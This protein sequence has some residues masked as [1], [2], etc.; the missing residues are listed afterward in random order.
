VTTPTA[1]PGDS[2]NAVAR[3]SDFWD[4]TG[5]EK[6]FS[7]RAADLLSRLECRRVDSIEE[8]EAIFRLRRQA[9]LREG[10]PESFR[11]VTDHYDGAKNTYIFAFYVDGELASSFRLHIGS[12]EYPNFPSLA[13]F[14]E[15]LQA[16][17]DAH[18]I[19]VETTRLVTDER[20]SRLHRELPYVTLRLCALAAEYYTA[21]YW[22]A[23]VKAEHRAF[24][25]RAFN[26]RSVC[27]V[28]PSQ[29]PDK[30]ISLM[31][32]D[33]PNAASELYRKYPFFRS[34][35]FEQRKLFECRQHDV[36]LGRGP[37]SSPIISPAMPGH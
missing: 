21:D 6:C 13:V 20:L 27:E 19:V 18:K 10:A 3:P 1:R 36:F 2:V 5:P 16:E 30:P 15:H 8:G 28:R 23:A 37:R 25:R 34:S 32:L 9:Y 31:M 22:L 4:R 24:Y 35:F 33:F 7:E 29:R 14:P 17:L 11:A 26:H 12:A